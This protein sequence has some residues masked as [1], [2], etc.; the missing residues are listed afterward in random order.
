MASLG[1]PA[2]P[3]TAP[4]TR[5]LAETRPVNLAFDCTYCHEGKHSGQ[6]TMYTGQAESLGLPKM[7][8]PMYLANVDCIGCHYREE[9]SAEDREFKGHTIAASLN[10]CVKCHGTSF[11]GIIDETKAE[12]K[13]TIVPLEEKIA[14]TEKALAGSTLS[15]A[16]K[17]PLE[18][19]LSRT[20]HWHRFVSS[21][22]GEHNIYLASTVLRKEDSSLS[23]IGQKLALK[24]P[25]LSSL[26]LISGSYCA[27]MCHSRI[28]VKVPPETVKAS[29]GS[30]SDRVMPHEMH[31]T[32]MGC[33]TCHRIGSHKEVPLQKNVKKE[34]CTGC[35]P[36]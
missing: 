28:G 13:K 21:S 3:E 6:L 35:H 15:P 24:L 32:L 22:R 7:P 4:E 26:P 14:A 10:A 27:T 2:F 20:R 34:V 12:L 31:T 8:S 5:P 23:E 11:A 1:E 25:D 19:L 29:P 30:G 17:K 18:E 9:N 16:E 36:E 33:V